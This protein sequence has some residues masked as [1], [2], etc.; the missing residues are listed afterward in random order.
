[1]ILQTFPS[2]YSQSIPAES[3]QRH[4]PRLSHPWIGLSPS[5][6]QSYWW[7]GDT[8][9]FDLLSPVREEGVI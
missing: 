5:L 3:S 6:R 1:M 9:N 7:E 8:H 4:L 2:L